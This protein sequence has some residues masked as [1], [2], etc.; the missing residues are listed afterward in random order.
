MHSVECPASSFHFFRYYGLS[1]LPISLRALTKHVQI[2]RRCRYDGDGMYIEIM[3]YFVRAEPD[4][5]DFLMPGFTTTDV[6]SYISSET[7]TSDQ[8]DYDDENDV[9]EEDEDDDDDD[10]DDDDH[11]D[12]GERPA[13]EV[14]AA[15]D[16]TVAAKK[17]HRTSSVSCCRL[18]LYTYK[19]IPTT[20]S[21]LPRLRIA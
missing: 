7:D 19:T 8:G 17:S 20:T 13:S 5:R 18:S 1:W 12:D 4:S 9:S 16:S 6:R 14:I 11:G 15:D 10:D 2:V 3:T 21:L